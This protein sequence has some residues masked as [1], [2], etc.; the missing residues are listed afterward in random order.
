MPQGPCVILIHIASVWVPFTSEAKEAI[1]HYPS[2]I[3]EV[4]L[5]LNEIGRNLYRYVAKKRK[6]H[7]ELKKRS[8]IEKYI[9]SVAKALKELLYYSDVEEKNVIKLLEDL[10]EEQRGEI[11]D[12]SFDEKKNIEY[13]AEFAKIGKEEEDEPGNEEDS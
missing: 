7:D 4:K 5:A 12:M 6:V 8:F 2:I 10:L 1:A 9:P 11:E 3:K 13:D